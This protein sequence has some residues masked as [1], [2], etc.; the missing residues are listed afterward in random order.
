[1]IKK[2]LRF[3]NIEATI[4]ESGDKIEDEMMEIEESEISSEV[5]EQEDDGEAIEVDSRDEDHVGTVVDA[6]LES[7][8]ED[9]VVTDAVQVELES[10]YDDDYV[11]TDEVVGPRPNEKEPITEEAVT[12]ELK[13]AEEADESVYLSPEASFSSSENNVKSEEPIVISTVDN[14]DV[15]VLSEEETFEVLEKPDKN[16]ALNRMV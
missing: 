16:D 9:R 6:E 15:G 2:S 7:S 4:E 13:K 12:V 11:V 1:M 3:Q 5:Q 10:S 8:D 14:N